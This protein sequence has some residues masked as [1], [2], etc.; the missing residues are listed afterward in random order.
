MGM[1]CC[2]AA[3][4]LRSTAQSLIG[5]ERASLAGSE[6][7]RLFYVYCDESV[8]AYESSDVEDCAG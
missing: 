5:S 3:S 8:D 7:D 6:V 1:R 4:G 2:G